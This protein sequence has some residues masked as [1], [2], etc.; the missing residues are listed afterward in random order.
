[1]RYSRHFREKWRD[2]MGEWPKRREIRRLLE[3]AMCVQQGG[4]IERRNGRVF[5][6]PTIKVHWQRQL[7]FKI[8]ER[9]NTLIT[10][11]VGKRLKN[12]LKRNGKE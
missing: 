2:F 7:L 11:Y 5:V 10:V 4:E 6:L 9:S 8:D 1:M 3:E 12:G